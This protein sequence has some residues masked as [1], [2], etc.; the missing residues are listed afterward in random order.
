MNFVILL[1]EIV[2]CLTALAVIMADWFIDTQHPQ[3]AGWLAYIAGVGLLSALGV[4]VG[5]QLA[6]FQSTQNFFGSF[7]ADNFSWFFRL[8]LL[9][10]ALLTIMISVAYVTERITDAAEFYALLCLATLG[11]LFMTAATELLTLYLSVE[12]LGISSYILVGLRKDNIR[13]SEAAIKY[14]IFGAISSGLM[15]YGM[16]WLFG[17]TGHI[18]YA[19]I[20][21]ALGNADKTLSLQLLITVLLL[22]GGLGYKISAVPFH[23]W[24]PDVYQGA[25]L[26]VTAFLSAVSKIA[27]F[28]ALLRILEMLTVPYLTP[29]WTLVVIAM[30]VLSMTLGNILAIAQKDIKRMFAYSSIAQAGYLLVGVVALSSTTAKATGLAAIMYYLASYALMNLGAFAVIIHFSRQARSTEINAF[31]GMAVKSPWFAFVLAACLV[32]LTGLPPFA[33][34]TGK[35]YLFGAAIQSGS[36][37]V[38][39]VFVGLLNSVISLYY[40]SRLIKVM[41]F[42]KADE[43]LEFSLPS[44]SLALVT[45][46]SMVGLVGLFVYPSLILG[47]ATNLAALIPALN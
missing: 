13:S 47:F 1:P 38:W 32:S 10:S 33:G 41:Y 31:A 35:F 37:Y 4:L 19:E 43:S 20:A 36:E 27:G 25:P 18:R 44:P 46:I 14:L 2:V 24:T 5:L 3:R 28:V 21:M 8:V 39:L 30:A 15:L 29:L 40:Y 12:L 45:V 16:S 23:M 42:G 26:P 7:T 34:F 11:A 9:G 6:G 17:L 22:L